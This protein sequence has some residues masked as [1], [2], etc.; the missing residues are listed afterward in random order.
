MVPA[1]TQCHTSSSV[2]NDAG[3]ETT[4]E[5]VRTHLNGYWHAFRSRH[6][7][8]CRLCQLDIIRLWLVAGRDISCGCERDRYNP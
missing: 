7:T 2:I 8:L 4:P 1:S 3:M 5:R 6:R